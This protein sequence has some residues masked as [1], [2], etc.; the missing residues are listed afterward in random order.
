VTQ[1]IHVWHA[2]SR[3]RKVETVKLRWRVSYKVGGEVKQ[4]MG[5]VP[6]FTVA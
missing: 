4:E 6:E 5:E 1:S 2:G 3:D